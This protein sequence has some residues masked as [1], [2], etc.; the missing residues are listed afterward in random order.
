MKISLWVID[1]LVRHQN[2]IEQLSEVIKKTDLRVMSEKENNHLSD[3]GWNCKSMEWRTAFD[4]KSVVV[5]L[6]SNRLNLS[7]WYLI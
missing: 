7:S 3:F 6:L 4:T 5:I 1:K 2:R